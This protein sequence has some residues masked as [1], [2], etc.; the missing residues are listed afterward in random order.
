MHMAQVSARTSPVSDTTTSGG[1]SGPSPK[2]HCL[3]GPLAFGA[4]DAAASFGIGLAPRACEKCRASKRK[5]DKKLPFCNRCQRLGARCYYA[6]DAA[7]NVIPAGAAPFFIYQPRSPAADVLLRGAEPLSGVTAGQ[8]LALV[9]SGAGPG[10]PPPGDWRA[11]ADAYFACVYPWFAVVHPGVFARQAADLLGSGSGGGSSADPHPAAALAAKDLALV[12]AAMALAARMRETDAGEQPVFDE[13]YRAVKRLLAARLVACA[14][15][16]HPGVEAA[17]AAALLA[18]YEY[19]H[20]DAAA[21]YRTLG[22]AA[23][24]ARALGVGPGRLA[25]RGLGATA[26]AL[27][28]GGVGTGGEEEEEQEEGEGEEGEEQQRNGCLWWGMFILEQFIHQD[29]AVRGLPFLLESPSRD[30]LL[31]DTPP[32]LPPPR[33]SLGSTSPPA[34]PRS[35]ATPTPTPTPTRRRPR[36]SVR[37]RAGGADLAAFQLSAKASTLFHRA[38]RI[39]KERGRRPGGAPLAAAYAELDGEI[40]RATLALLE[41]TLDWEAALDCFA[42][43][44]SALFTLYMPYLAILEQTPADALAASSSLSSPP[45]FGAPSSSS[46]SSSFSASPAPP[47]RSA[48]MEL[49]TALAALR[50][51]CKMSTDILCKLNRD[52]ARVAASSPPPRRYRHRSSP[53][54]LCAPAPATCYL[55]ILALAGLGRVC[56]AEAPACEAIIA[57]KFETLRIFSFRWGIAETMMRRLE[58]RLGISRERYLQRATIVPPPLHACFGGGP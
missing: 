23:A 11:G 17:Q 18:L 7:N 51:A 19:G 34:P 1:S 47:P 9:A 8:I 27:G 21:A 52:Y 40:R 32:P 12:A 33:R 41:R 39:D 4:V 15:D 25:G 30:T 48:D 20:G 53:A 55:V 3:E 49:A 2:R 50:F 44:V 31:P 6:R 57:D 45:G 26:C 37:A 42:M 13:T 5:C 56:P 54:Y 14:G 22:L 43:L 46:S 35:P 10:C 29:E 24:T 38:L 36:L 16:P 58:A 28:S